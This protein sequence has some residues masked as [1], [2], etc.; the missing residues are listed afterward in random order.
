M[1]VIKKIL[2]LSFYPKLYYVEIIWCHAEIKLNCHIKNKT[3]NHFTKLT[4][5]FSPIQ[6]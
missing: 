4:V 2:L 1:E 6:K 3:Q 5:D